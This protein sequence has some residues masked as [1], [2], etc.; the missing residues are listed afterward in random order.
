M[1]DRSDRIRV[2]RTGATGGQS[3]SVSGTSAATAS[4][5]GAQECVIYSTVECF[6]VAGSTPTATVA[7]GTPIPANTL[8]RVEGLLPTDTIAFITSGGSGTV[9]VRPGV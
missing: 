3:V 6:A 9:Y 2:A 1:A 5:I 7:N 4:T 8:I